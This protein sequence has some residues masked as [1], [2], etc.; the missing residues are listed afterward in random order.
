M[1]VRY[2]IPDDQA[3]ATYSVNRGVPV[4]MSH[5]DSRLGKAVRTF[6]GELAREVMG[7]D[8]LEEPSNRLF[9]R[10]RGRPGSARSLER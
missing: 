4:I 8:A 9:G 7:A 1:R 3:L 5:A 6:A 2:R 10:F